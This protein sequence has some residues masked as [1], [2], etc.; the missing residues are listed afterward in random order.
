VYLNNT[1]TGKDA[2]MELIDCENHIKIFKYECSSNYTEEQDVVI[3]FYKNG[4]CINTLTNPDIGQ[5]YDFM[6]HYPDNGNE[7]VHTNSSGSD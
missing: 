4:K 7:L 5:I 6:D 3:S 2:L 1:L